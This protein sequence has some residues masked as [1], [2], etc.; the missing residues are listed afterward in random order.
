LADRL[1]AG[2][3][4]RGPES[5]RIW[6]DDEPYVNFVG[7]S[8]LA[9]QSTDELRSAGQRAL[10]LGHPWSQMSS[11]AYG[12]SDPV[13]DEIA[14]E[15]A[16]YFGRETCVFMP[17]GYFSGPA[18][19]AGLQGSF[20]LILIDELAHFSLLDAAW[21]AGCP[22][23]AF[24]HADA[25]AVQDL[26]RQKCSGQRPLLLTDGVFA[27]SGRLPPLAE[28]AQILRTV[29]G[30]LF[31]DESHA[32][33]VVGPAGQG[34][35]EHCGVAS[36][37][38]AG[39]LGKGFCAQGA[40]L[41][42]SSEFA[43]RVRALPPLRGAGAGSPVSALV[44]AAALR[45]ARQEPQRRERL[46]QLTQRLKTGLRGLGLHILQTPAPITSFRTG[47]RTQMESLQRSLFAVGLHVVIS[48][49]I[50]SGPEGV[51]RC[52][53]FADHT[54]ADIDRLVAALGERL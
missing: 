12:G 53:T 29:G 28:Y 50:G 8:Y 27:T 6:I 49:Y 34:A 33:G 44:G 16:L 43:V 15:G 18:A 22:V 45:L 35:A 26:V 54:E 4:V 9:L 19:V 48:N 46:H 24:T 13:F 37:H 21:L 38:H 40:L 20:D 52:A 31:I 51:F 17:T 32:Y 36:A 1:L 23:F 41:P 3:Q 25:N 7:C 30:Q 39:T 10:D 2:R 5:A 42:C 14:A 11:S 47:T